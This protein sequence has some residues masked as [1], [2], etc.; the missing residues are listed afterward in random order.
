MAAEPDRCV[1]PAYVG[2][3]G[4]FDARLDVEQDCDELADLVTDIYRMTAPMRL[5]KLLDP[6]KP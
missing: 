6:P 1:V 3:K 4:W 2:H 5:V